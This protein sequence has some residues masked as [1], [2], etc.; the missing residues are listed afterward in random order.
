MNKNRPFI[1]KQLNINAPHNT[2]LLNSKKIV[3]NK[4]VF[5]N[6]KQNPIMV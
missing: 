6:D 4:D 3:N 2:I 1:S 5:I